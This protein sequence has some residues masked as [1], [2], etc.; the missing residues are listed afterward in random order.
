MAS[1]RFTRIYSSLLRIVALGR[2]AIEL[3]AKKEIHFLAASIAYYTFAALIPLLLVAFIVASAIGG[4]D[5]AFRIIVVTQDFLTPTSQEMIREAILQTEGRIG[6]VLGSIVVF[7]WSLFRL[8]RSLDIAVSIVYETELSP[9]M[10]TQISTA[11]MLFLV[12]LIAGGGLIGISVFITVPSE[13]PFIGVIAWGTAL[14]APVLIFWPIYYLLPAVDHSIRDAFPGT[15]VAAGSWM[16]L[17]VLFGIYT[18]IAGQYSVYGLLGGVLLLLLWFYLSGMI[19][20]F[21]AVVN[22]VLY[23]E[24][25]SSSRHEQGPTIQP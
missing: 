1:H 25:R 2:E 18:A 23:R 21:G 6:V 7:A 15:I 10:R 9:S 14:I 17:N 13:L 11:G 19:L 24:A 5:L 12:L 3:A 4:H 22:A 16:L 8:L 20:V